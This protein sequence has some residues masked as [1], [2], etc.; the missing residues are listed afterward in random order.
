VHLVPFDD[1]PLSG[2]LLDRI[3]SH[4]DVPRS[5]N[6]KCSNDRLGKPV[7]ATRQRVG[8]AWE[9][10]RWCFQGS[11][12]LTNA[13]T[14]A[15]ASERSAGASAQQVHFSARAYHCILWLALTVADLRG[16]DE[17]ETAHLV[18]MIQYWPPCQF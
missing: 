12:L 11:R 3:V 18:E 13:D 4:I 2:L 14:P 17:I 16:S 10:H 5:G 9:Q 15:L 7:A 6:K 8:V 1:Q